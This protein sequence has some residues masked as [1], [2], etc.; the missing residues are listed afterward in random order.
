[1]AKIVAVHSFRGGTGKSN[2]TANLATAIAATG[3]R[4]A[5][6]DTSIYS[7]GIHV[8]FNVEPEKLPYRLNDYLWGNCA[9]AE[10]TC[11]VS[12]DVVQQASGRLYLIPSSC[13]AKDIS[14]MLQEGYD[15]RLL[16]SGFTDLIEALNLDYI[17]TDTHP[18]L[19]EETLLCMATSDSLMVILRPDQQDYQGTE[20]MVSLAHK[21]KVSRILLV[22]NRVLQ[23]V[24]FATLRQQIEATYEAPVAGLFPNCDQ[25]MELASSDLV[26]L[27]FPDHPFSQEMRSV[28]EQVMA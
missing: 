23:T 21:L 25:I 7:P 8:L 26:Y 27:R 17:F 19:N 3:Q 14:R 5:I 18:G 24:E 4:V 22:V 28:A 15:V 6:I 20:I 12:P 1:M 9:I 13:S 11:D 10:T 16:K 2:I